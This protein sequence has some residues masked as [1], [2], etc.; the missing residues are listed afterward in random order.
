MIWK[1]LHH[2]WTLL[3]ISG[4]HT[5]LPVMRSFDNLY[6]VSFFSTLWGCQWCDHVRRLDTHVTS[7]RYGIDD[8]CSIIGII[9][10]STANIKTSNI[11]NNEDDSLV[12]SEFHSQK[13]SDAEML[14]KNRQKDI[15]LIFLFLWTTRSQHLMPRRPSS[16]PHSGDYKFTNAFL[17]DGKRL[18]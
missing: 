11:R 5:K 18:T 17:S 13:A 4:F 14:E 16:F 15:G 3:V 9:V 1:R 10:C 2:Y 7:L 8:R 6:V 12:I